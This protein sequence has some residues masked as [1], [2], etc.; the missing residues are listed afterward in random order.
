MVEIISLFVIFLFL[1]WFLWVWRV[2]LFLNCVRWSRCALA[3]ER[4]YAII[5]IIMIKSLS[6]NELLYCFSFVCY[7]S[8]AHCEV[9]NAY[10]IRFSSLRAILFH[11]IR[12]FF[13]YYWNRSWYLLFWSFSFALNVS[14]YV[15]I[16]HFGPVCNSCNIFEMPKASHTY[17]YVDNKCRTCSRFNVQC[18]KFNIILWARQVNGIWVSN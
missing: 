17:L 8:C 11:L 2:D 16:F 15:N 1:R 9:C 7:V 10:S 13:I 6:N 14:E 12:I 5:I 3:V 18:S 4:W